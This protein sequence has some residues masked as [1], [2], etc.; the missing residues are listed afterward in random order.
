VTA[1][2]E[3]PDTTGSEFLIWLPAELSELVPER[4]GK[5]PSRLPARRVAVIE[6]TEDAA[7]S[8]RLRKV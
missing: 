5:P 2:D 6:D 8:L 4:P 7:D 3:S 1:R